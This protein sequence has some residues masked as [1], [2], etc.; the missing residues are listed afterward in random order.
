MVCDSRGGEMRIVADVFEY[1]SRRDRPKG[2]E[3]E[4]SCLADRMNVCCAK[5]P[6]ILAI[7]SPTC[8]AVAL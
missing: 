6:V 7:V 1:L 5:Q 4:D 2:V 8:P 3:T